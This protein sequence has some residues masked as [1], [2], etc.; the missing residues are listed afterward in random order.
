MPTPV[1]A[2]KLFP[3][4]RRPDL[5]ARPRL[6][7]AL[8]GTLVPGHRLTLVSAAAGFGKTTLLSD[9]VG[10]LPR[11][12]ERVA[13][14]SLDDDDNALPRFL[15]HLW[16]ALAG[17]DL[18]LDP[19]LVEV[20][21]DSPAPA[22]LTAVVN[23]VVRAGQEQP[24]AHWLLVLDDYHVIDAADVHEALTFLLD[25]LPDHLHLVVATRSDPPLPLAR[26]RSRGQL[27]ELRAA[28]LRFSAEEAREL[29]RGVRHLE[30]TDADVQAL[31]E[32][33]EGWVAGLQLVAL[34]L[35]GL[36]DRGEVDDFIQDFTGSHRFV[37]DYLM[38]EVLARQRPEVRD[39][40]LRTAVLDRLTGSLCDALTGGTHGTDVLEELE[41]HNVF[42]VPLDPGRTW[43]RYHHLFG[44]VL[45]ARLGAERPE[46]VPVLHRAASAWYSEHGLVPDAVRHAL[47]AA[48]PERA[49][50]LMETGLA[51][52]RRSRQDR[53]LLEW[54]AALPESVVR[55]SPVLSTLSAWSRMMTGDLVGMERCLDDAEAALAAGDA[56]PTLAAAWPDTE[57]QRA[58][59]ATVEVYRAALAQA[60]G[61][62]ADTVRHAQRALE[63]AGAEDHFVRGA[64]GGFLGLASWATGDVEQALE[65]FSDA[66]RNLHAAGNLVD[67]LDSTVVLGDMWVTAGRPHQARRLYEKALATATGHGAPYPR[68]AADLHVGLAELDRERND[69]AGAREHLETARV[70]GERASITENRHRWFVAMAQ[71]LAAEGDHA[72]AGQLLDRAEALYRPG[73]YPDVRPIHARR[74]RLHLMAGDLAAAEEWARGHRV[75]VTDPATF[76]DEYAQLTFVRLL[77][78]RHDPQTHDEALAL[79]DRLEPGPESGRGGSLLEVGVLRALTYDLRGDRGEAVAELDRALAR[80]PEPDGYTRLFLDEGAAMQ[81]LLRAAADQDRGGTDG[82]RRHARR[83][84]TTTVIPSALP[85]PLSERELEVLRL[86]ESELTGPEIARRLFVSLNTLRTHTKRIFTKLDVNSRS[87]AVRRGRELDLL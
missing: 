79:L 74:A 61:N 52:V 3:P 20:L 60:R 15:V 83:L 72:G 84:L 44:D 32:R 53:L 57:D 54:V 43:H 17:T 86:L 29:L 40:L 75:T 46:E 80:A 55:R 21:V 87:A 41:R 58:A 45:R 31:E 25:H 19:D 77:L 70:L 7:H 73:F 27:T 69:L 1:L 8:G 85:D 13:W 50:Y 30:V 28:D 76:L 26:L 82:L 63:Q 10:D 23:E 81:A 64:A 11:H 9:W 51:E 33:T 62:V 38:D 16:A 65:T 12:R 67:E 5:V 24:D 2:T 34:S 71:L 48:D 49:A 22:T 39:F 18:D 66:L 37:L 42:L 35:R 68:A 47:A 56:D 59:A 14:L 6:V 36:P 4:A 78:A